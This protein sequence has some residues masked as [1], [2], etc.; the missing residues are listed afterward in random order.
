VLDGGELRARL[1]RARL[2][3]IFTPSLC[4]AREPLDVLDAALPWLDVV[5][6]RPKAADS[7]AS[8][9]DSA[10]TAE[11]TSARELCDWT[12]RVIELVKRRALVIVND[13]VDVAR[14]LRDE[15]CDGVHV[16]HDDTPPRV[17]RDLLGPDALVGFST[18]TLA[19]VGAAQDEPVDYLGFG[20]IHAT[21]TKGYARGLGPDAA[22]V[23][24]QGSALP[25]FPIG[26]I[27]IEQASDLASLGRAAVSSAI[28]RADDPALAAR[29]L[30]ELL[31]E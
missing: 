3:L 22:W 19:Q 11:R 10:S 1:G 24:Q 6:V 12:R 18:H 28:L 8:P 30:R 26:G 23:A 27:G 7:G 5:Q 9:S 20:P 15:G 13:R 16:G 31:S 21:A 2:Y 25:V 14:T 4:L 29:T 17:A